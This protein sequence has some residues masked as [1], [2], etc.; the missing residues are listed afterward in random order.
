MAACASYFCM[1]P[2]FLGRASA[3]FGLLLTAAM[4]LAKVVP[5]VPGHFTRPEW[6]AL[7]IYGL[8]GFALWS[9]RHDEGAAQA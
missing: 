1:K 4:I 9:R 6:I 8:L 5:Y 7:G 3:I 2:S